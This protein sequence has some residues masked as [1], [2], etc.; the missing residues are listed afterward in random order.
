[1]L[2]LAETTRGNQ[3]GATGY[4]HHDITDLDAFA[5]LDVRK[6]PIY[7]LSKSKGMVPDPVSGYYALIDG[8]D[9]VLPTRPVS[10]GYKLVP[11]LD[12][13]RTQVAQLME[14]NL[15]TDNVTVID[16]TF[17]GGL[18]ATREI[19]FHDL[20][21][22]IPLLNGE[23][24]GQLAR[25]DTIN[26][27]DQSWA[28]QA[29]AGAYRAYCRNQQVFGGQKVYHAKRKHTRNLSPEAITANSIVGIDTF[30]NNRD[31][32][33]KMTQI[34]VD[35]EDWASLMLATICRKKGKLADTV[36]LADAAMKYT[37]PAQI[38][39]ALLGQLVTRFDEEAQELGRTLWA[40]YNALTA[41][42]THVAE[43][44][45]YL[46]YTTTEVK[47]RKARTTNP[48]RV[49]HVQMQ[50]QAQVREVMDS[51]Q[52]RELVAA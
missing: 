28:F 41:W 40:G 35:R 25:M 11:H 1:M 7:T 30:A 39:H 23:S 6:A 24:D 33:R 26:S 13:F 47:S 48:N 12:M 36:A 51:A 19:R 15:P 8:D 52:W 37:H 29:F 42:A 45:T 34:Q 32:F 17:D 27:I 16:R 2:N 3:T 5:G 14:S 18:R 9:N 4:E 49:P 46:D 43:D 10:K 44:V 21:L 38:N 31:Y 22:D 20:R 50:R